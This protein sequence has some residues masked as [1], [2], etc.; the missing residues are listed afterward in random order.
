[1]PGIKGI[2]NT[3][4]STA[5]DILY[6]RKNTGF[7]PVVVCGG[8][9]VG[10][11]TAEFVSNVSQDVTILEM[12]PGILNDMSILSK[13]L[14]MGCL[15]QRGV[16]IIT[17]AKV[18]EITENSVC[19]EDAGGNTVSVPAETVISAFGYKAYNPLEETA[20]KIC[21][22]VYVIGCAVK[23]GNAVTAMREGYEASPKL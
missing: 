13:I 22:E 9:E 11:E 1:M 7:G 14:L 6:G 5:E 23:A 4:V 15:Q 10:G 19:Y 20:R 2:D 18:T 16:K 21:D 3:N 8:G 12:Q 17:G